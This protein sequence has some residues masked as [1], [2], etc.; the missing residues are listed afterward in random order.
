MRRRIGIHGATE[1]ALQ[2]IPLL[3]ANPEIELAAVFDPEARAAR[4]RWSASDPELVA[5]LTE[6]PRTLVDDPRLL[7]IPR[8]SE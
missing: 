7:P 6:D 4:E 5:F 8:F 1:E 3:A 2:L